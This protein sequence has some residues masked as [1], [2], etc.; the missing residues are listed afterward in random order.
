[1]KEELSSLVKEVHTNNGK[2]P[3]HLIDNMFRIHNELFPNNLEFNKGCG[4]CRNR[5]FNRLQSYY[6]T[7]CK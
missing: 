1:M 5:V 7:N 3:E 6:N 4:N 2:I